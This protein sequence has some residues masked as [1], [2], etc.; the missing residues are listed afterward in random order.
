[1]PAHSNDANDQAIPADHIEPLIFDSPEQAAQAAGLMDEFVRSYTEDKGRQSD[2]EW[3]RNK[4]Q[5]YP[6]WTGQQELDATVTE[7]VVTL[8]RNAALEADRD[9]SLRQGQSASSWLGRQL[10]Q[11][12]GVSGVANVGRYASD[13]EQAIAKANQNNIDA[14]TRLDGQINLGNNLDGFI[15]EHHHANTFNLDA[16]AKASDLQAKVLTPNGEPFGKNSVDIEVSRNGQKVADYQSKYGADGKAT[17]KAFERGDYENQ[18]KLVPEGQTAQVEGSVDAIEHDGVSSRPL[19]KEEAKEMQ[20]QAQR[21]HEARQY[22]WNDVNRP[23]IL[24]Q[25]GKQALMGACIAT[26]MQGARIL[27]RRC[28][29][30]MQGKANPSANEDMRE[31]FLSAARS[32]GQVAMQTAVTG[33]LVVAAKNGLLGGMLKATPAGRLANIAYV[34]MENAKILYRLSQGELNSDEALD[35][36][37]Q[38]TTVAVLS[39]AAA[40]E[41]ALL[42]AGIGATLG[43]VGVFVG[44]FV[45]GVVGGIAGGAIGPAIY[46]GGKA[47]VK[48]AAAVVVALDNMVARGVS[49]VFDM[50]ASLLAW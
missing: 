23:A 46:E 19:S 37:G 49:R 28:W 42:G 17:G 21:E 15:A 10:E 48:R 47:L 7:I 44:G 39:L 24:K 35:A 6:V 43:P 20:D 14:I 8:R 2:E 13:I 26:G 16:A 31:F 4:L 22:E 38:T 30:R 27:G 33:A 25:I 29:N 9:A 1:M 36:M 12:A 11:A 50:A 5:Q 40:G 45:G 41:G 18:T 34:G 32:S 3:L